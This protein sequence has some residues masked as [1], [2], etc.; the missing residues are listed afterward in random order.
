MFAI[1]FRI[2][3]WITI[4]TL[5][6]SLRF[7]HFSLHFRKMGKWMLL[8]VCALKCSWNEIELTSS[9]GTDM[10]QQLA[11]F[12]LV[13]CYVSILNVAFLVNA[14][15]FA[16]WVNRWLWRFS[17]YIVWLPVPCKLLYWCLALCGLINL[18]NCGIAF[19]E[20]C[21]SCVEIMEYEYFTLSTNKVA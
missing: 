21:I 9:F 15:F 12:C 6:R 19:I 13:L 17:T 3:R 2:K 4:K 8:C 14:I 1:P 18:L 10:E 5:I 20:G 7:V 16:K 11:G